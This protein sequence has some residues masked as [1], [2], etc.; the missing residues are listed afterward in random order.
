MFRRHKTVLGLGIGLALAAGTLAWLPANPL[1]APKWDVVVVDENGRVVEGITV[2][3]IWQNYSVEMVGHEEDRQTDANGRAIF[4]ARESDYSV[5]RQLAGT[6]F[7]SIR[8][9]PHSSYGPHATV[10]AF[11]K[12]L[13]GGA[14]TGDY[15]LDW[16]GSPPSVSCR[17]VAK[18]VHD[19]S[20]ARSR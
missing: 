14:T 8:L 16:T 13:E 1:A 6:A 18:P 17:I 5:L 3:E 2:R 9:N 7:A 20:S 11:G 4:E 15:V 19:A 10:F 12:G